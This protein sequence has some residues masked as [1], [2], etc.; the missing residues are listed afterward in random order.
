[1][2]T[3]GCQQITVV[4][5]RLGAAAP[6]TGTLIGLRD[7]ALI[8]VMGVHVRAYRCRPHDEGGRLLHSKAPRLGAAA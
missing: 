8:A 3:F 6:N 2:I 4:P 7:C 5:V 1:M